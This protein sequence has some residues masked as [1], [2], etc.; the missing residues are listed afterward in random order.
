MSFRTFTFIFYL[1]VGWISESHVRIKL[2]PHDVLKN[3]LK[4]QI[5]LLSRCAI[6]KDLFL[7]AFFIV[8]GW[9]GT[10]S[11]NV[12]YVF[13][14]YVSLMNRIMYEKVNFF[15]LDFGIF[16]PFL[17]RN[18]YVY[19]S[20]YIFPCL[21]S[22]AEKRHRFHI[23]ID[24]LYTNKNCVSCF[25]LLGKALRHHEHSQIRQDSIHIYVSCVHGHGCPCRL[26]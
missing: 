25:K 5:S 8:Y 17:F 10:V 20:I 24:A 9:R 12:D 18:N 1:Q 2:H 15:F 7:M 21:Q 4:N 11:S 23:H 19:I 14:N 6:L 26:I 22:T 13:L 16:L 3:L